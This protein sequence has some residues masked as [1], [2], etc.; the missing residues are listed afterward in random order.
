MNF[1][2]QII[3]SKITFTIILLTSITSIIAFPPNVRSI[4]SVRK[5]EWFGRFKFNAFAIFKHKQVYRIVSYGFIHGDWMHLA[6]NMITLYFFGGLV[7]QTFELLFGTLGGIVYVGFYVLALVVSSIQDLITHR[8]HSYYNAVGASGAV[9]AVLF[10]AIL[11]QPDMKLFFILIP[12]PITAWI[13][14]IIY[15]IYSVVMSRKNL[16]NIGHTAHF[17][18]AVFGF[19]FPL[20]F[21]PRLIILF[22]ERLF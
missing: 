16:D 1:L 8:N 20:F 19:V 7:E 21:Y 17:W 10:A 11:F 12:I 6:F 14:G 3:A 2:E 5:P 13:F 4:E 15:L 22:F 18:G 9:S